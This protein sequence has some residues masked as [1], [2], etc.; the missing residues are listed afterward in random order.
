M[1]YFDL[2]TNSL[3]KHCKLFI[4]LKCKDPLFAFYSIAE[5]V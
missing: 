3:Q 4:I 5:A 2:F 1:K